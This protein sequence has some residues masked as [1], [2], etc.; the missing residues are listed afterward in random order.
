MSLPLAKKVELPPAYWS[1]VAMQ[2][3]PRPAPVPSII[4]L[5]QPDAAQPGSIPSR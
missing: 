1:N 2:R 5:L 3:D 4:D